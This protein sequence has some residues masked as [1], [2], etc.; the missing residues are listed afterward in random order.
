MELI[1]TYWTWR[2]MCDAGM[3]TSALVPTTPKS[4]LCLIYEEPLRV[5]MQIWPPSFRQRRLQPD[6]RLRYRNNAEQ[7]DP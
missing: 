3:S 4:H 6:G 7:T 2:K 5:A 1:E